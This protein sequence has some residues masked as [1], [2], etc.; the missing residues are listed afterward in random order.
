[1]RRIFAVASL[2]LVGLFS[3]PAGA[4]LVMW[5]GQLT[6]DSLANAASFGKS[7]RLL[8]VS[9]ESFEVPTTNAGLGSTYD[10]MFQS[11]MPVGLQD[12][13]YGWTAVVTTTGGRTAAAVLTSADGLVGTD[14]DYQGIYNGDGKTVT[15][16]GKG[17]DMLAPFVNVVG[18]NLTNNGVVY[19]W[20]GNYVG[21][22]A[23]WTGSGPD[24][25]GAFG[26]SGDDYRMGSTNS[27]NRMAG[28]ATATNDDWL[29]RGLLPVSTT[30]GSGF[31]NYSARLYA[32]S[33]VMT[34]VPE[35]G[36]ILLWLG[37]AGLAGCVYWR[38]RRS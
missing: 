22:A 5:G 32:I 16:S 33:N 21:N 26:G 20:A 37:A 10:T 7:Y 30:S 23:V 25:L 38:R 14:P 8:V 11:N 1:M 9:A 24:G 19:D 28:L 13:L 29:A 4:E 18:Q 31:G 3:Q 12:P 15:V 35:P 34:V 6:P 27:T 2:L 36:S 17:A